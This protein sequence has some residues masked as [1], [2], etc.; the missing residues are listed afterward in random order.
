[1]THN[2]TINL[3]SALK[4]VDGIESFKVNYAI[5]KNIS[6][7]EK[8]MKIYQKQQREINEITKDFNNER[9]KLC[10]ELSKDK[11]GNPVKSED[12]SIFI[13][14]D[15]KQKEFD[16]KFEK[17]KVKHKKA[18]DSQTKKKEEFVN[19]L[20]TDSKFKPYNISI[21]DIPENISTKNMKAI[22]PLI[23]E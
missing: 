2:E 15:A 21:E 17:L 13:F 23:K 19:F 4:S 8:E 22:F 1:M 12:G 20:E 11:D 7:L 5:E 9:I 10:E 3:S 18:I 14:T 6:M 16:L